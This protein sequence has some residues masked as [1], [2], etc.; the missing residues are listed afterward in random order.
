MTWFTHLPPPARVAQPRASRAGSSSQ[1]LGAQQGMGQAAPSCRPCRRGEDI[2]APSQ[3]KDGGPSR[4][5]DPVTSHTASPTST[6]VPS[7]Q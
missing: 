6:A 1:Q 4:S 5:E 2:P 7:G 3:D